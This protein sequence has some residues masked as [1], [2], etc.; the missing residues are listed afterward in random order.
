MLTRFFN[1]FNFINFFYVLKTIIIVLFS[2]ERL[3]IFKFNRRRSYNIIGELII[4]FLQFLLILKDI[5]SVEVKYLN[6]I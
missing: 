2:I 3:P 5:R 1:I 4:T 6:E